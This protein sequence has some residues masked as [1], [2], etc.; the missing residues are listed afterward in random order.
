MSASSLPI[1]PTILALIFFAGKR[2]ADICRA[3]THGYSC[4]ICTI[5]YSAY[6]G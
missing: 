1:L 3:V 6:D 2:R 5:W 4:K